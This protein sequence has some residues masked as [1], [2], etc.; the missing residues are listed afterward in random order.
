[1]LLNFVTATRYRSRE[2]SVTQAS[3]SGRR[4]NRLTRQRRSPPRSRSAKPIDTAG[5]R[6]RSPSPA[7]LVS[8]G[9]CVR[10]SV[11]TIK[12]LEAAE[13]APWGAARNTPKA[14]GGTGKRR[15]RFSG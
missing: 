11:P 9:D 6:P 15:D 4:R 12:R 10:N 7:G 8:I 2:R 1:P 5:S 14:Q 3:G 13:G